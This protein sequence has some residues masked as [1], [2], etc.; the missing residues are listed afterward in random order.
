MVEAWSLNINRGIDNDSG[1][2]FIS[3]LDDIFN[4]A[5]PDVVFLQEVPLTQGDVTKDL[6]VGLN[7]LG[8]KHVVSYSL[9]PIW[10]N[11]EGDTAGVAIASSSPLTEVR[12]DQLANPNLRGPGERSNQV[13]FDK[14]VVSVTMTVGEKSLRLGCTHLIPFRRFGVSPNSPSV[15]RMWGSFEAILD[16]EEWHMV[17]GDFN[18]THNVP[19]RSILGSYDPYPG[20]GRPTTA[21]AQ[22]HDRIYTRRPLRIARGQVRPTPS[23]HSAVGVIVTFDD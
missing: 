23:D 18:M 1:A 4:D 2:E 7:A 14:G 9:E 8:L 11:V 13:T 5:R 22:S 15:R 10:L 20:D 12:Y 3:R 19:L 21:W 16:T 6:L 17:A